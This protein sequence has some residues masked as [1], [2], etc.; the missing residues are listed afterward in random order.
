MS[1][2]WRAIY[3]C[4]LGH[5]GYTSPVCSY[6]GCDRTATMY[7]WAAYECSDGEFTDTGPLHS[8]GIL[9]SWIS[10]D[11]VFAVFLLDGED[12]KSVIITDTETNEFLEFSSRLELWREVQN[13][14]PPM[15][16]VLIKAMEELR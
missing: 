8:F 14:T 16:R 10:K 4:T 13:R 1:T 11:G 3:K 15:R 2:E 7:S 6:E 12:G 5:E 9:N